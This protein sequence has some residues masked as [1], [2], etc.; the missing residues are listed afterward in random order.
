MQW[1]AKV[2]AMPCVTKI[3]THAHTT[4]VHCID[5]RVCNARAWVGNSCSGCVQQIVFKSLLDNR[6]THELA[7]YGTCNVHVRKCM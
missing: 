7:R 4:P 2:H 1:Q 5:T 6:T 3:G